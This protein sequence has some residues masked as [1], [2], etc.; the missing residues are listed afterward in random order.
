MKGATQL[1]SSRVSNPK[2]SLRDSGC[3]PEASNVLHQEFCWRPREEGSGIRVEGPETKGQLRETAQWE[4]EKGAGAKSVGTG[5]GAQGKP[6]RVI[7]PGRQRREDYRGWKLLACKRQRRERGRG[8]GPPRGRAGGKAPSRHPIPNRAARRA[9]YLRS[10]AA[11][12]SECLVLSLPPFCPAPSAPALWRLPG[13]T[14]AVAEQEASEKK[15]KRGRKKKSQRDSVC[16]G[17]LP[18]LLLLLPLLPKSR[19]GK[20]DAL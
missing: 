4:E 5:R 6:G 15:K 14:H 2:G 10:R 20:C 9:P 19:R 1:V 18:L 3:F 13:R 11:Q 8:K 12:R 16:S 17:Q 7:Q